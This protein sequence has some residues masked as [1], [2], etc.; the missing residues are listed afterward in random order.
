M[1][2]D[3]VFGLLGK[4]K[5]VVIVIL[6]HLEK[7]KLAENVVTRI[8]ENLEYL[9]LTIKKIEPHI[10]KDSDAEEIK[11]F[12]T[13]LQKASES[14]VSISEK[15]IVVKLATAPAVLIKLHDTEAEVKAARDKLVL[16]I[17]SNTL[18][19][20]WDNTD[21]QDKKLCKIACVQE[22]SMVGLTVIEDKSVRPPTAPDLT[23]QERKN[24]LILSWK[25]SRGNVDDYEVCYDEHE[26]LIVP[27]G[28]VTTVEIGSPQVLPGNV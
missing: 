17:T 26:N 6:D 10:K 23:I 4:A 27:V 2:V 16:F 7:L 28:K 8:K 14:C 3:T 11:N 20:F 22:N 19:K 9:Q 13:H 5:D 21:F 18:T 1:P 24:K 15:H 25:P 12:L